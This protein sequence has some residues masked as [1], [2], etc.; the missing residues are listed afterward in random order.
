MA[1]PLQG[2]DPPISVTYGLPQ[3]T[4]STAAATL[5]TPIH[6]LATIM[7][8]LFCGSPHPT[9]QRH[10]LPMKRRGVYSEKRDR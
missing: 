3:I 9:I 2:T 10:H 4:C 6:Q 8:S 1:K 5:T 7:V